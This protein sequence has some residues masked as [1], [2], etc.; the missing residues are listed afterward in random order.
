MYIAASSQVSTAATSAIVKTYAYM[1]AGITTGHSLS[2]PLS[3]LNADDIILF[4]FYVIK[5]G[6]SDVCTVTLGLNDG[7]NKN[8]QWSATIGAGVYPMFAMVTNGF[9]AFT[10]TTNATG[11]L[12]ISMPAVTSAVLALSAPAATSTIYGVCISR[13]SKAGTVV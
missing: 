2:I 12:A 4:E 5:T 11:T 7:S 9:Q 3:G 10:G 13:L 8:I 6:G 1:D